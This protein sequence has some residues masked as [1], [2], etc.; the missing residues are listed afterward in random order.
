MTTCSGCS[1]TITPAEV[2]TVR[3][4]LVD[5]MS[6]DGGDLCAECADKRTKLDTAMRKTGWGRYPPPEVRND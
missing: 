2:T 3:D 4:A 5:M 6:Y 1:K